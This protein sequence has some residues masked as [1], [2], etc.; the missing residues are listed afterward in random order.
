MPAGAD[1]GGHDRMSTTVGRARDLARE[2]CA[3]P[4]ATARAGTSPC[5]AWTSMSRWAASTASSGPTAR[6]RPRRSGCCSGWSRADAGTHAHLRHRGARAASRTSSA[7]SARSSR[8]P[9][10]FP[11]FSGRQNLILLADA[12]G[13]PARGS[14]RCSRRRASASRGKDRFRSYSLGMKQRLAIAATLLKD[15]DLLIFDEPTNGLDPAGIREIRDDDA[16][17]RRAGQDGAGQQPHPRRG[18]AGRRLRLDHRP[19]AAA[20]LGAGRRQ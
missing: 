2:G 16:V 10:F 4:T 1:D 6:A 11:A 8:Q 20:R 5:R 12:I 14:T 15:P 9:K 18:R 3:R 17:A 19:R 7:G 13:A